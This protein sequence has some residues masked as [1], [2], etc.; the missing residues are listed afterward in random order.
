[1][2]KETAKNKMI[3]KI[4]FQKQRVELEKIGLVK[5][6]S[7]WS[8]IRQK[9]IKKYL[10]Y[11]FK[12]VK[13]SIRKERGSMV[14]AVFIEVDADTEKTREIRKA[15]R[16]FCSGKTD[17]YSDYHWD[18]KNTFQQYFGSFQYVTVQSKTEW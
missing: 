5:V 12:G 17:Y 7:P 13:M 14:D 16:I 4:E 15:A 1:M 6:D 11:K 18:E 9:N 2:N 10:S 3:E 8:N